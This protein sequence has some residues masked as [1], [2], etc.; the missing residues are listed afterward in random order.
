MKCFYCHLPIDMS[1][2]EVWES[3]DV[4]AV[5]AK[6]KSLRKSV[7]LYAHA[8]CHAKRQDVL[9]TLSSEAKEALVAQVS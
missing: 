4:L 9:R 5:K 6:S 1:R 2:E 7:E 3:A 8:G